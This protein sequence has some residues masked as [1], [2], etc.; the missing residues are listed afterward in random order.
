VDATDNSHFVDV[1]VQGQNFHSV[2]YNSRGQP[3]ASYDGAI[4][5]S[6]VQGSAYL[7]PTPPDAKLFVVPQ[8]ELVD[9][10]NMR[11]SDDATRLLGTFV[12]NSK[13][14]ATKIE[15]VRP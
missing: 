10:I 13:K 14:M 7:E 11:L 15:W 2:E 4:A 12:A 9:T 8:R 6:N 5:N 3:I 1:I